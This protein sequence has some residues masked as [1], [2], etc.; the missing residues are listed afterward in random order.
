MLLR[1]R[2]NAVSNADMGVAPSRGSDRQRGAPRHLRHRRVF[3][4]QDNSTASTRTYQRGHSYLIRCKSS[5]WQCRDWFGLRPFQRPN[6]LQSSAMSGADIENCR[7]RLRWI[8]A[9]LALVQALVVTV[10]RERFV[11]AIG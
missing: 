10:Q 7:C 8:I 2:A 11:E 4:D 6:A 5:A 1:I 3:Y 9:S